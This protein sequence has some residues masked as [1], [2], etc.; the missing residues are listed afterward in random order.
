MLETKF[1]SDFLWQKRSIVNLLESPLPTKI[2]LGTEHGGWRELPEA[3]QI[4][5]VSWLLDILSKPDN[6]KIVMKTRYV[7]DLLHNEG[8]RY[9]SA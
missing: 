8:R 5:S 7:R 6:F 9:K 2:G 3:R 1:S 4:A